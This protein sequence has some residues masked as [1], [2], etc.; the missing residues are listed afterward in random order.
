[1]AVTHPE[2]VSFARIPDIRSM[3][4]LIQVPLDSFAWVKREGLR[5]LF[6]ESGFTNWCG[7]RQSGA[8]RRGADRCSWRIGGHP[9]SH[10]ILPV[11][12][13][14]AGLT[15]VF[16]AVAAAKF[17]DALLGNAQPS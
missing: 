12:V 2:R 13:W 10:H 3:S 9:A 8:G 5:Q 15:T 14:M 16:G 11:L 17:Y 1:M 4:S 7:R 6:A